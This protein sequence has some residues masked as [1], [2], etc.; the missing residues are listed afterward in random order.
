MEVE[1]E[2]YVTGEI[3]I[4]VQPEENP[5]PNFIGEQ[6]FN[7]ENPLHVAD[8][9]PIAHLIRVE[10]EGQAILD[11]KSMPIYNCLIKAWD[12]IQ[13]ASAVIM[14]IGIWGGIITFLLWIYNPYIFGMPNDDN[15]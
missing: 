7:I 13:I 3:L 14:I 6:T 5:E 11:P 2:T 15:Y 10:V 12:Y 1:G 9:I 8:N 4:T